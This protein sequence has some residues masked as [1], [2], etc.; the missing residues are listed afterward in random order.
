MSKDYYKILGVGK[1]ASS[2]EIKKA[3]R[4]LA[5]QYHP[6][7]QGGSEEKFKEINEAYQVLGDAEKRKKYD[8]FGS[9]FEQQGG[10]GGAG[11]WEDFMRAAR[12]QGGQAGGFQ[13]DFGGMDMGDIFG[14]LFGGSRG[15][16]AGRSRGQD[17]QVDVQIEFR[18]AAFGVEKEIHLMKQNDCAVCSGSG[19]EPGSS[20][21]SCTVCHGRGQVE[22]VQR[23]IF[24][25]MQTLV[26]CGN[27]G[28]RGQIPE[29]KVQ[30]LF[31]Q[32]SSKKRIKNKS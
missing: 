3:F 25:A 30:T 23:T 24:G 15:R 26:T 8:Q 32:R 6:D 14:D 27:C 21:K 4:K 31:R 20:L 7:K 16:R 10:F 22:Q 28:G 29:K 17:I 5:H 11:S 13:F 18:E 9:D 19:V 12:G 1:G 2:D